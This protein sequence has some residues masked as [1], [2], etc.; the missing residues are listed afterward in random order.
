MLKKGFTIIF[1]LFIIFSLLSL[2]KIEDKELSMQNEEL[3]SNYFQNKDSKNTDTFEEAYLGI[4][5]IK[6]INL[7]RGFY[8]YSSKLNNVNKNITIISKECTPNNNCDFILASHS[9]TSNISFFKNLDKLSLKDKATIY[10]NKNIYNY[11]LVKINHITKN[12]T[13]SIIS[14]NEKR[15]IL[16]TCNKENDNIQEVYYFNLV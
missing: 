2:E 9:G 10:Y 8:N 12:G 4:L 14:S 7:K 3:V 15:L 13:L 1:S 11:E 5:E 16:T 6:S